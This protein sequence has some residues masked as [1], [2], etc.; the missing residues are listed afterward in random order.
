MMY[1]SFFVLDHTVH[2]WNVP[3]HFPITVEG[4]A[5]HDKY[6]NYHLRILLDGLGNDVI[7]VPII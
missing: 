2:I 6:I 4:G 7:L 1:L 3:S 5:A